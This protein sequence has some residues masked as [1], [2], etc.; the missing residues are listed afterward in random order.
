MHIERV[1]YRGC[2]YEGI[3]IIIN[4]F[5]NPF[6]VKKFNLYQSEEMTGKLGYDITYCDLVKKKIYSR[7]WLD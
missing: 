1:H 5:K 2:T 6:N 7:L 4:K 3:S